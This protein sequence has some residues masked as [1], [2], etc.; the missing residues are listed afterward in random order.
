MRDSSTSSRHQ[1]SNTIRE[2]VCSSCQQ[3]L[4]TTSGTPCN[5]GSGTMQAAGEG[6]QMRK[7]LGLED[8]DLRKGGLR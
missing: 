7:A 5:C 8:T 4:L 3:R 2:C 1:T 6:G